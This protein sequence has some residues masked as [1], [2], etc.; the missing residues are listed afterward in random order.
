MAF[1]NSLKTVYFVGIGG[2][3]MSSLAS[4]LLHL[5]VKVVGS[6]KC[7]DGCRHLIQQG[8]TVFEGHNAGNLPN[9]TQMLVYSQ[10]VPS[11]NPEVQKALSLG[12]PIVSREQ[13]LGEIF[14]CYQRRVA[15]CG[16]HGKT[17]VTAMIDYLLRALGVEHTAFI[18]G[19]C[20]DSNTNY[21]FG[22]G[23]VV[24]EACEYKNSFFNLFPTLT[25]ALNVEYDHPDFF[26]SLTKV[27]RS[28]EK[29]F[30]KLPPKG[31]LLAHSSL[32]QKLLL[33]K[34]YVTFGNGGYYQAQ[35]VVATSNGFTFDF[36]K[37]EKVYFTKLKY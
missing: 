30:S 19:F 23:L 12:I 37:G 36:C 7:L 27:E 1:V 21:T 35:N 11:T 5:G 15:V 4:H 16:T 31:L 9:D 24:A 34:N 22:N 8:A 26:A 32:P 10:A 17:T 14:N 28:F 29:F 2:V 18:G 6:D 33:G 20:S 13:L 3:G 25:V